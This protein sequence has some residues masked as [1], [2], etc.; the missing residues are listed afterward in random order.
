LSSV[1]SEDLIRFLSAVRRR[2][3]LKG[4][5]QVSDHTM[6][7]YHRTLAALFAYLEERDLRKPNPMAFVPRPKVAEYLIRPFSGDQL[8][9]LLARPDTES[10]TGLRDLTLMCFLLDTG[11]RIS[12]CLSMPL[13]HV[14][15]ERRVARVMG[16]GRKEREV[17][18]GC[19][20]LAWLE[21]YLERRAASQATQ[22]LFV[23]QYGECLTPN[24]VCHRISAYGRAAGLRGVRVSPHTFRH[25][26]GVNWLLGT[27]EYKGDTLSLQR[28]L[29]HS[30]PAMT[31]KYVHFAGQDLRKLHDRLSPGDQLA[32]P[33]P[34]RR[35]R[36]L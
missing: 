10:F 20:T 15:L 6:L 32:P 29:G 17:P 2:P 11:C 33:P 5:R 16:K 1:T 22:L 19:R 24:A 9:K 3:G 31:Q 30:T 21:R 4:R 7:A 27:G 25:T 18:F 23:N 12:E 28:I 13:D 34:E 8:Q 35:R 26:F 14:D 36:L